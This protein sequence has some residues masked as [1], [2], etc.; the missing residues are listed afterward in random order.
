[1]TTEIA[2]KALKEIAA[3]RR[4]NRSGFMQRIAREEMVE[5]AKRALIEI[6]K[7]SPREA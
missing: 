7:S 6:E 5:I 2:I 1:M 4:R 3:E